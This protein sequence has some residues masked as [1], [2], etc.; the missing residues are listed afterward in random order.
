MTNDKSSE[1]KQRPRPSRSDIERAL[2]AKSKRPVKKNKRP[3]EIRP[4][5]H[6]EPRRQQVIGGKLGGIH[7]G[8]LDRYK[9]LK[10][11][12]WIAIAIVLLILLVFFWPNS[13][14]S[15]KEIESPEALVQ[16]ILGETDLSES[17]KADFL[18]SESENPELNFSRNSDLD[19]VTAFRNQERQ[20]T[21]IKALLS[22]AELHV[23]KGQYSLPEDANA[24]ADYQ[25]I[26]LISPTNRAAKQG[27]SFINSRFLEIGLL[28]L[29][30]NK[31]KKAQNTLDKLALINPESDEYATLSSAIERWD[32]NN[33]I[34]S[35]NNRANLA[36]ENKN[37]L[38]PVNENA[39]YYF[40]QALQLNETDVTALAGVKQLAEIYV[41]Q[42]YEAIALGQWQVA[43]AHLA[44]VSVIDPKNEAIKTLG[45]ILSQP[46]TLSDNTTFSENITLSKNQNSSDI[47]ITAS[48]KNKTSESVRSPSL[49]TLEQQTFDKQY[50][51]QGL[52][53]YYT[54]NYKKASA[55]FQPLAD[56]GIARA[57]IRLAYMHYLGREFRQNTDKA[58]TIVKGALPAIQKFANEGRS[59]AQ[60]DLGS[61]Y[62]DGIV[63]PRDLNKAISWYQSAAE[64]G[65]SV[66][67]TNL[68]LMY[69]RGRGVNSNRERAIEWFKKAA[70]QGD[71]IAQRNLNTLGVKN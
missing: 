60:S 15:T 64:Q 63:L 51:K 32:L 37:F 55:L 29:E 43:A 16:P 36:L 52:E 70:S 27:L 19:R 17:E 44:T 71:E 3:P 18:T 25:Q 12:N 69:A 34:E 62:E 7:K 59:W 66:A 57:Q 2:S 38:L 5:L 9:H 24:M 21:K 39:L 45:A 58:R 40:K 31:F 46:S 49:Q 41:Q 11:A 30:E 22:R 42:T 56:K 54:G 1:K 8:V 6:T 13:Q 67:Q 47:V 14:E 48:P 35:F 61:L 53:A 20:D 26:L 50:L 10:I 65:Y 4:N 28:E 33:Q 68:G 23:S